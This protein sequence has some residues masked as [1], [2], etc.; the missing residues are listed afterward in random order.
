MKRRA[1]TVQATPTNVAVIRCAVTPAACAALA[2]APL[3]NGVATACLSWTLT[4][5]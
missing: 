1:N 4:A 3:G 5:R 2:P